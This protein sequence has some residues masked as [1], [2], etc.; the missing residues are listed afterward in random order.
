MTATADT[1]PLR[2][3]LAVMARVRDIAISAKN[4]ARDTYIAKLT[5]HGKQPY[6]AHFEA[7]RTAALASEP[8][9]GTVRPTADD[10]A[11]FKSWCKCTQDHQE[12][13]SCN[14]GICIAQRDAIADA[15]SLSP[16]GRA[17][18][19]QE[20]ALAYHYGNPAR[21]V[22][23]TPPAPGAADRAAVIEECAKVADDFAAYEQT[24]VDRAHADPA[25][26]DTGRKGIVHSAGSRQVAAEQIAHDIRSLAPANTGETDRCPYPVISDHS[27]RACIEAGHCGCDKGS[28][29]P[30]AD[31]GAK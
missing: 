16:Q 23:A 1:N 8:V 21:Y 27:A 28:S 25:L 4:D 17:P 6:I 15:L 20:R 3:A 31:G 2:E 7:L 18:T 14:G 22:S 12:Y 26:S 30:R 29:L 24:V 13:E 9:A 11:D 19:D 10:L 5:F